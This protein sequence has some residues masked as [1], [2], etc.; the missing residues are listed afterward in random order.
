[1]KPLP[2]ILPSLLVIALLFSFASPL[3]L[4]SPPPPETPTGAVPSGEGPWVVRAYYADRQM[5]NT[6]AARMEPWEVHPDQGYLVVAVDREGYEWLLAQGFRVEVDEEQ[7]T[8]LNLPNLPLPGQVSGIPGY[9]CYRTVEETYAA[10]AA[11]AAAHPNLATWTDIGDSWEKVTP[12]G[13]PGYDL[14]VLRLT[15]SAIAGPKPKLFIM[16]AIHARE[17]ATAELVTRFAEYL[18]SHYGT[19][20]DVTW[21]LDH[22]EIHFLLHAN[23]DGRK[24]A[25]GGSSWRKNTDNDDGCIYSSYWGTDLNRNYPFRW[26]CCG[27]SSPDPCDETYRGPAAASEPETQAVLNYV[28]A[29]FP[30]Q[31]ADPLDAAA[32]ITATGI[33]LDIHS[34]SELVLWPWGFTSSPAPNGTALQTLGRKFAY[35]NGY[36]PEQSYGLYPTDGTTD[37]FAYGELGLAAYTFEIGTSFFQSCSYFENTIVPENLPALLYAAKVVRTPY[38][39]P[40]GP[41]ALNVTPSPASVAAGEPI[42]LTATINDTRYNNS[43]G[44]EPTQNIAAAEYYIDVP[45]WITDP[46]PVAHPMA[47]LDGAFNQKVEGVRATVDTSSLSA[48]RHLVF[49]RGQDAAGNWGAFSAAFFTVTVALPPQ[50]SVG[51]SASVGRVEAGMPL[52]YTL[53]ITNTGGPAGMATLTDTLPANVLFAWADGGGGREG[54]A[55]VWRGLTVPSGGTLSVS[56]GVTVT[57][58]PSGT[59]I[60]NDGYEV[61][62][63]EWPTPTTGLPVT[64][65]TTAEGVSADFTYGPLPVLVNRA[66]NF[67]NLSR[68]ATAYEWAFGDSAASTAP[69][70]SHTYN[71]TGSYTVVL[72]AT[73]LCDSAVVSQA[74]RVENY[75]LALVPDTGTQSGNPGRTVTY[76]LRL[77]NTGTLSDTFLLS[78]GSTSWATTLSTNTVALEAGEGAAVGVYVTIPANAAGGSQA[79]VQ[80]TARSQKDP[81]VPPASASVALTTK[82]NNVHGVALGAAAVEQM[83]EAGGVVTYTLR[84]TN[85]GNVVDTFV[86]T[87]T[88]AGWPTVISPAQQTIARGGWRTVL[89]RVTVPAEATAETP[90]DVAVIRAVSQ[91]D[92]ARMAEVALTTRVVGYRVRLPLVARGFLP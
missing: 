20:P 46:V 10:A 27:G 22:H 89:V 53:T 80:V 21:L 6:L 15:N 30:D 11:I 81:R 34:Y 68:N 14:M 85:T 74:L 4:A 38:L 71:I 45:P 64:V 28:R 25:E 19:D 32:P 42:Y 7:T 8:R 31:R 1:V 91:G 41:D 26:G 40:S 16:A 2:N 52:S 69:D 77:T 35:F 39:T 36:S 70:P 67:T 49:V 56:Y 48:G 76:T 3:A 86:F 50:L 24:I 60:V 23:P 79:T 82:A 33:F 58:V 72:T 17:Y 43:G 54:D 61:T 51:K 83:A 73:N 78:R 13:N 87:R 44:T 57:C 9:P 75:A 90:P 66:V 59:T 84:V 55:V 65:T 5:L 12:G 37:D 88:T 92:P 47:P 18:V 62:A 63:A 29:Q